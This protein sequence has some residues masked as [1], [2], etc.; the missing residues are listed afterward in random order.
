MKDIKL[1]QSFY[2]R[3]RKGTVSDSS[4]L[5]NDFKQVNSIKQ[6]PT[7]L[8]QTWFDVLLHDNFDMAK[9]ILEEANE[10]HRNSCTI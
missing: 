2:K 8:Y 9:K 10:S 1:F 5:Q 6:L 7:S 3:K 4:F